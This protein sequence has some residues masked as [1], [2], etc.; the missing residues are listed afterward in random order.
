MSGCWEAMSTEG[1][2]WR[3]SVSPHPPALSPSWRRGENPRIGGSDEFAGSITEGTRKIVI[4]E[5]V[6]SRP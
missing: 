4:S 1:C 2:C 6:Y 5:P 3:T